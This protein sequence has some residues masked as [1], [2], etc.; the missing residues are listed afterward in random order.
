LGQL[1]DPGTR[2]HFESLTPAEAFTDEAFLRMKEL[3]DRFQESL[4]RIFFDLDTPLRDFNRK[5]GVF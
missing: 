3:S 4:T 1:D 5:Y 2:P